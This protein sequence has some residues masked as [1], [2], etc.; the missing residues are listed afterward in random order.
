MIHKLTHSSTFGPVGDGTVITARWN[1]CN[2][3]PHWGRTYDHI[4]LIERDP[5]GTFPCL[6]LAHYPTSINLV[7]W[8]QKGFFAHLT[9]SQPTL[10]EPTPGS[11][12]CTE[13]I[14]PR[15]R[16]IIFALCFSG[17]V[18][19]RCWSGGYLQIWGRGREAPTRIA[20]NLLE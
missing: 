1:K 20:R 17:Y 3:K 7:K 11:C 10:K 9:I 12:R 5:N 19:Y 18:N 8:W 16:Q 2:E 14:W 15:P 4:N 6:P 13:L